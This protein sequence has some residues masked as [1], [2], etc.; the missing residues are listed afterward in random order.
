MPYR[1]LEDVA[2]ADVAFEAEGKTLR[3]LLESAA[4]AATNAMIRNIDKLDHKVIRNFEVTAENPEM[5]LYRFLQEL[6]FYKDAERLLFNKFE[7]EPKQGVP[8]WR[9]RVRAF[10]DEISQEKHELLADVKAVSLHNFSVRQTPEGWR[11]EVIVDV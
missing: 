10:G 1:Y 3:E 8:S 11:A 5:L 4:L 9:L 7:L 6:V 2:I